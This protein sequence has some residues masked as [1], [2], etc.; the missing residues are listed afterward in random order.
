MVIK[1]Y[2]WLI[3]ASFLWG[4]NVLVM[5]YMLEHVSSYT[6]A[7]MKV[8]LSI[9]AIVVVMKY[10][11]I[12]FKKHSGYLGLKVGLLSITLNFILTFA[13]LNLISC[14]ANAIINSLAPLVT[15]LL[16]YF[17]YHQKV[18]KN[19]FIAMILACLAFLISFNFKLSELSIGHLMLV[20]AIVLYSCGNLLL[21]HHC[22]EEDNLSFTLEYLC[23]GFIQLLVITIIFPQ[24]NNFNDVSFFLWLLFIVFSGIGFAIIQLIYFKAVHQIGSIETSFLLGLN[25]IFTYLGSLL[26][27]EP[28]EINKMIAMLLMVLSMII[29]NKKIVKAIFRNI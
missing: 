7:I 2:G 5:R 8:F 22:K 21:Q 24:S 1:M 17:L 13:G 12:K 4:T 11:Q 29:A 6:L 10:K 9:I 25:P 15:I 14:S 26:L 20:T 27:Q 18:N 23:Y 19:Q 3:F 28:F 16:A